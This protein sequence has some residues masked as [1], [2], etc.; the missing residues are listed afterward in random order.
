MMQLALFSYCS[1]TRWAVLVLVANINTYPV[2]KEIQYG[3]HVYSDGVRV[4][5]RVII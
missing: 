1:E 3:G 2:V 4:M 5:C